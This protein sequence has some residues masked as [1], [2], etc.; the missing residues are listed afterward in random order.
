MRSQLDL[1]CSEILIGKGPME[2]YA[3]RKGNTKL[4]SISELED[5]IIDELKKAFP[6]QNI[7]YLRYK[8]V[9]FK[10]IQ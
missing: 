2:V 4:A 5:S 3:D 7:F 6:N 10:L 8:E 9:S 1:I